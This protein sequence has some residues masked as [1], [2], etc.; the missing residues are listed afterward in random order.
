MKPCKCCKKPISPRGRNQSRPFVYCSTLCQNRWQNEQKIKAWMAGKYDGVRGRQL[1]LSQ[2]IRNYIL[3]KRGH[4]CNKCG[5]AVPHPVSGKVPV[6]VHHI[7]GNA[8]NTK[9]NNLEILCPNCH[10]L[11]PSWG[12]GNRGSGRK[13]KLTDNHKYRANKSRKQKR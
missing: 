7:D 8:L 1:Q 3:D 5:W 4:K 2:T 13:S 9:Q 12:A 11:T 6:Q 10:S